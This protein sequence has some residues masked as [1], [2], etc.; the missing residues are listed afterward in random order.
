MRLDRRLRTALQPCAAWM[1]APP[2]AVAQAPLPQPKPIVVPPM[3][4]PGQPA[5][6]PKPATPDPAPAQDSRPAAQAPATKPARTAAKP[7]DYGSTPVPWPVGS[8]DPA[9][10]PAGFPRVAG[11]WRSA[12]SMGPLTASAYFHCGEPPE[13]VARV[14]LAFLERERWERLTIPG[15]PLAELCILV[16]RKGDWSLRMDAAPHPLAGGTEVFLRV[17]LKPIPAKAQAEAKGVRE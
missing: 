14:Y 13:A 15:P 4:R 12:Y 9:H 10:F 5:A 16:A 7:A 3:P 6:R 17:S 8:T 1:L 11:T 2:W